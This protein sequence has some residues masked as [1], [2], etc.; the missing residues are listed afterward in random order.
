MSGLPIVMMGI[1]VALSLGTQ[2]PSSP[3]KPAPQPTPAKKPVVVEVQIVVGPREQL[4]GSCSKGDF[5]PHTILVTEKAMANGKATP[6]QVYHCVDTKFIPHADHGKNAD[7]DKAEVHLSAGDSVKWV[8]KAGPGFFIK[9]V[10]KP[11]A[12]LKNSNPASPFSK[13]FSTT[14]AN[15]VI[16]TPVV[17][18]G[19]VKPVV[20]RYKVTFNIDGQG[21]IDPDLVCSM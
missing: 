8:K 19:G 9:S 3:P 18:M 10:A 15:E 14:Y 13:P 16:S 6:N 20:Q 5:S 11:S 4:R 7:L 17:S 1:V 12:D 21:E 2:P